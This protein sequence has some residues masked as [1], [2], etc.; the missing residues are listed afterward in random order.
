LASPS[1]RALVSLL[2]INGVRLSEA[3]AAHSEALGLERGHRTLTVLRQGGKIVTI[4]LAPRTARAIDLA[5]GERIEGPIFL[6]HNGE[7][8]NPARRLADRATSDRHAAYVV[9]A[10]LAGPAR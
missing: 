4:P 10:F 5:L 1:E 8:L 2:A 3:L 9:A 6:G 7:R